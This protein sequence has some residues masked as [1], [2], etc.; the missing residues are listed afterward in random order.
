MKLHLI[1]LLLALLLLPGHALAQ[2]A[3]PTPQ[4]TP[5]AIAA[6]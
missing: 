6:R 1:P 3:T 2:D 4:T 5:A